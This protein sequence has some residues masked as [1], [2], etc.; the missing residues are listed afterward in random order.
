[1][2]TIRRIMGGITILF[3][4]M[5]RPSV[6]DRVPS[7]AT[8]MLVA[9]SACTPRNLIPA[10][11]QTDAAN[12]SMDVPAVL[13]DRPIISLD[14]RPAV[15]PDAMGDPCATFAMQTDDSLVIEQL[16]QCVGRPEVTDQ[17]ARM[18]ISTAVALVR[19]RGGFPAR[20]ARTTT[21]VYVR[22][23]Q[24][25]LED[26]AR[27]AD[28]DFAETRRVEPLSVVG[29]FNGWRA[30]ANRMVHRGHGLFTIELP[31]EVTAEVRWGYKFTATTGGGQTVFF[32]DPQS[33]R[34]QYDANGRISFVSGSPTSG[35][36]E[37]LNNVRS[38]RFARGRTLYVYLPPGY[39]QQPATRYP[40]LYMHDGNNIFDPAQPRSA[41]SSWDVDATT[42]TEIAANRINPCIIVGIENSNERFDEY[43]H[44]MD[45]VSGNL[46]GGAGREYLNFITQTIKPMMDARFRTR[47]ER[48]NTAIHGSSLGGLISYYAALEQPTVF[49]MFGG[50]SSTFG[51]GSFGGGTDTMLARFAMAGM[52]PQ[53]NTRYFLDSGGGPGAGG[54][55]VGMAADSA[56][57]NFCETTA[58]RDLLV[59]R[60][61]RTFVQD[62]NALMITPADANIEH[63]VELGAPHSELAWSRRFYRVL[64]FFF[65]R[66]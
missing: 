38:V 53:Q 2:K 58:M 61:V 14:D 7:P 40:V 50:M 22:D 41:P 44:N 3:G 15:G 26:D 27:S 5:Q 6:I 33:R 60:G 32:S 63:F 16:A 62:P 37:A 47:P 64:R 36:L 54:S 65:G 57:D 34:F 19:S 28:E 56:T 10:D 13:E 31:L 55:C 52:I 46:V 48:E 51:W 9:L 43:T 59:S 4:Q 45:R 11:A 20:T 1:M 25:D 35:H 29:E 21:F 42:D 49:S 30:N 39:E 8:L 12:S 23:A 17:A 24:F 18:A 66:R